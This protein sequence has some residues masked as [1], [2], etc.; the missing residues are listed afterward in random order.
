VI[1]PTESSFPGNTLDFPATGG[2][3]KTIE[4]LMTTPHGSSARCSQAREDFNHFAVMFA[5]SSLNIPTQ[6]QHD[7][8]LKN[9]D[10]SGDR[11]WDGSARS[12]DR[13]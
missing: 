10:S 6:L 4:G 13:S 9:I 7:A 5:V 11:V 3:V 8:P 1:P 2:G 12:A